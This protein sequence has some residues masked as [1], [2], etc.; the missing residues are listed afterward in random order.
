MLVDGLAEERIRWQNTVVSL[1]ESFDRLPGD[2]LISTGF[3]SYLGPFVSN[4][5]QE[6]MSIW[7]KEVSLWI[8]CATVYRNFPSSICAKNTTSSSRANKFYYT[9]IT[10]ATRAI[11]YDETEN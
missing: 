6:L 2:C 8:V 10:S 7:S 1:T 11:D 4:Y 3:L 9:P 5:R